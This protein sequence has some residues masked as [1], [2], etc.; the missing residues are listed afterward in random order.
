MRSSVE[1]LRAEARRSVETA[2]NSSE[3][4]LKKNYPSARFDYPSAPK[5]LQT[6][7]KTLRSLK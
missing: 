1:E 3:A 7:W 6:L 2:N 5:Q 4:Q